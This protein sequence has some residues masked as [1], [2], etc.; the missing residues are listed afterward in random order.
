MIDEVELSLLAHRRETPECQL[1]FDSVLLLQR[2]LKHFLDLAD[3]QRG[4][5]DYDLDSA[6]SCCLCHAQNKRG[7]DGDRANEK[8]DNVHQL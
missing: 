6:L 4:C 2:C 3:L 5:Q 7:G 1:T 8:G